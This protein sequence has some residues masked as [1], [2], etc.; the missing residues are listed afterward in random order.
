LIN[1]S[2]ENNRTQMNRIKVSRL[3]AVIADCWKPFLW[4]RNFHEKERMI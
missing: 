1:G 2:V 4:R 3:S